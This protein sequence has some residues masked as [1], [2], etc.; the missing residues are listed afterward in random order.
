[1]LRPP[2]LVVNF[3]LDE[4]IDAIK[5]SLFFPCCPLE[6][7]TSPSAKAANIW[8]IRVN[9]V[10]EWSIEIAA[11]SWIHHVALDRGRR[12]PDD[13]ER[14]QIVIGI[15]ATMK[16]LFE[17]HPGILRVAHVQATPNNADEQLC[18][19]CIPQHAPAAILSNEVNLHGCG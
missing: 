7:I 4:A 9:P 16:N 14:T 5:L 17:D 15:T 12:Y 3:S 8:A 6:V 13:H 1:M 18:F 19:I 11:G 10:F 2:F